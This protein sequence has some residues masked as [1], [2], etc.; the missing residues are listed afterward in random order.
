MLD[1]SKAI[2]EL[3]IA[4]RRDFHRNPELGYE[5]RRTSGIVADHLRSLGLEVRTGVGKTGVVGLLRGAEPGPT[6]LLRADMD[7][8]PIPDAK[9]APYRSTVE[10]KAHLCGHDAH[11]AMLMGA[12]KLLAERGLRRGSVKFM[13]QPAEEAGAGAKAM[14]EDG[15]LNDPSVDAAAAL[16][17]SPYHPLGKT[18]ASIGPAWAATNGLRIK[19]VGRGG[20][21]A[22][23][24]HT[25]DS[26]PIAAQ[27]VTALQQIASRQVDPLDSVVV[28]IGQIN[29][30]YAMNAIAPEVELLGTVRTLNPKLREQMRGKIES[31]VKGVTEAFGARY[32]L[33]LRDGYPVVAN[34]EAMYER[35]ARTS[36]EV[37]GAGNREKIPPTMGGEDFAFVAGR[38]PAVMFRL[39]TRSGDDTAYPLHHPS[40]DLDESAMPFGAAMLA[41]LAIDYLEGL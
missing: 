14:I 16:H 12:A 29:G 31:I 13:F 18:A 21:A 22:S 41:S 15:V 33:E 40:F 7:A 3:M 39:G 1:S 36:D 4:W 23:P 6:F 32:E 35:F 17:V 11:T 25:I 34:D 5:E 38:V 2:A 26:I 37:M 19:I 27:V 30:G 28:T 9:S 10:G 24:H 20:H 8:L